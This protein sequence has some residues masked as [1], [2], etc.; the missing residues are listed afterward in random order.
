MADNKSTGESKK[1]FT[2]EEAAQRRA[3]VTKFY[4]T[5]LPHL[6]AQLE[7]EKLLTDIEQTRVTRIQAQMFLAQTYANSEEGDEDRDITEAKKEFQDASN[8]INKSFTHPYKAS[9]RK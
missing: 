9:M 1:D 5:N 2:K 6:K 8:E 7:Y 4:K 3:E